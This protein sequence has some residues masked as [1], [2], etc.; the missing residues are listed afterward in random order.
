MRKISL[1]KKNKVVI[2]SIKIKENQ[3]SNKISNK[4]ILKMRKHTK[5]KKD[6][7][8]IY[9]KSFNIRIKGIKINTKVKYQIKNNKENSMIKIIKG[10]ETS[11]N[12]IMKNI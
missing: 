11:E 7:R 8:A 1:I 9:S 5:T 12:E 2:K 4:K 10:M 3:S 6:K